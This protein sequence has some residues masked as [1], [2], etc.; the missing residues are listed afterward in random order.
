MRR[1]RRE[2]G[3]RAPAETRFQ[4]PPRAPIGIA[5]MLVDRGV[6]RFKGGSD[7]ESCTARA[8]TPARK[9]AQPSESAI[10]PSSG[11]NA[12]ARAISAVASGNICPRSSM[13]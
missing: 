9:Y 2:I 5:Q 4:P 13:A 6:T 3:R 12:A 10:K 8:S 11:R 7:F 1:F